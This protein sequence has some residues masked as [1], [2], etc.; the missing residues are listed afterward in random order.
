M[1]D[2]YIFLKR[3]FEA[4]LFGWLM[5]FFSTFGQTFLISLYVPFILADLSL[6]KSEFGS[7]YAIA[8][9]IASLFLLR[10]GHIIDERP[11]RGF[12]YSTILLLAIA[13]ILLAVVWH[14]AVLF[15]ALVGLRLGGQGLMSHISMTVMSRYFTKNRGK[16]LSLSSLGYSMAEMTFPLLMAFIITFTGW[17]IS[18]VIGAAILFILVYFLRFLNIEKLDTPEIIAESDEKPSFS[19]REVFNYNRRVSDVADKEIKPD[20]IGKRAFYKSMLKESRFWVLAPPS[21]MLSFTITGFF[22]YQYIMVE[23]NGWPLGIYTLFF[24]GYGV[25]RLIFSLFGG[26]LTDRYSAITLFVYHLIPMLVGVLAIAFVPGFTAALIFLLSFGITIGIGGVVKPAII[27][28]LYGL[29][30]IGQVR[31]LYTVVMVM[32]TA[33]A[34]LVFGVALDLGV[35]FETLGLLSAITLALAILNS[36]RLYKYAAKPM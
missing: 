3:H 18:M 20:I 4:V 31:S 12:T 6:G 35:S 34:P 25:V 26:I 14:P 32:S 23:V 29:E 16:A 21:F 13:C 28:E 2:Y 30:R 7:Y 36:L 11:V 33:L 27:A 22:F 17:R 10:F 9:V 5:T 24:A 19:L 1:T 8:T 15:I